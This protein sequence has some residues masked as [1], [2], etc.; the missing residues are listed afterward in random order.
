MEDYF[1]TTEKKETDLADYSAV[2]RRA[3]G[4]NRVGGGFI[5]HRNFQ[6]YAQ[7]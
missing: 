5:Y 6:Q 4:G 3:A 2:C 1:G 7:G